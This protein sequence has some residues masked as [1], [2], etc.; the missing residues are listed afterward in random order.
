MVV[1]RT[2]NM[3]DYEA[4]RRNFSLEVPEYFN[5]ATDVI[6][7]WASDPNKL[8]MLWI[9]QNGEERNLTF[10]HF[11]EYSSRAANAFAKL[12]IQKG[13]RVLV[14]LPRVPEWWESVLGL[15]KLGAIPIPCTTLLTP[16]DIAFRAEA[17][18][19]NAI[20]T[21]D[22]GAAKFDQVRSESPTIKNAIVVEPNADTGGREGWTSYHHVVQEASPEFTGPKTRSDDPCLVYFTSGTVGYPKMV[23]HTHASYP[24]GHTITGKYWL[25]LHEDDLHWNLSE[26]GWAKAAW[27][28][29][30]GPWVMGAAMF[31]Q[32]AR[33]KF[34]PIE[35]LDML[36]KYPITTLCAPPTAYRMLVL[37]E[38]LKYMKEHPPKA[39]RHCVG[40]GE[41]LNPEV[42]KVWEDATRMTIRDGYGQTETVLLC[43]NF[44]PIPVKPGSMG[45]PSP[46]FD[47]EVI[48]HDGNPLPPNKEGDIAVRIKPN[49]PTWMFKEYWRNPDATNA[50]IRGDWYITGDRAYKDEDGY[51][52]FVGRADDVIISAG[53]RIGPFEVESALKEHPA[54]AESAV[55]ASPDEMRGEIVKAFVIL[56]PGYTASSELATELQEHVKKVTAPYKYPREIEFV[57]SLPKTI[58]GKIRRVELRERERQRKLGK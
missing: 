16:K 9:G 13:D 5:F 24:I 47:V 39:L 11:A 46:G 22:E 10:A 45:K 20:I 35:T 7:K 48:D 41:P 55:V 4:E 18:E 3:T 58:S 29:L 38:P 51:F 40:A 21:D 36:N 15:M 1:S 34:N 32:D 14:M 53:Y 25:D 26:M 44:P 43:G 31:I 6:G 37:D 17:A 30:F 49:R 23:L 28:N 50:C 19:A 42:I 8:A 54:V 2:P 56:A 57:D 27:S 12:G 33:G 52:W